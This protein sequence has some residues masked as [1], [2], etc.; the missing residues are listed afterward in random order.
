MDFAPVFD[1]LAHSIRGIPQSDLLL[2]AMVAMLLGLLGSLMIRRVPFVGRL[3]RVAS[4][5]MLVGVLLLVVLQLSRLDPRFDLAVPEFGLPEQVVEGGETRVPLSRDGHFWLE[6]EINGQRA[7]FMV[8]TGATLTAISQST[9]DMAG[10]DARD[11][12]LPIRLQTANGAVSASLTTIDELRFGNVA[13]RG[14]DAVIAPGLGDTNVIGMNL[15]SRLASV[16]IEQGELIL[17]PN[18]PQ[19]PLESAE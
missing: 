6:A 8:D 1:Q 13:A 10:L 7:A 16:R 15:L 3:M 5:L 19:P 14:L 18:N 17:T 11:G 2:A 9:A 4:T 12:G